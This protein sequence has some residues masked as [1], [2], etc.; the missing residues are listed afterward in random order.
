MHSISQ[1]KISRHLAQLR[2]GGLLTDKREGQWVYYQINRE[3]PRWAREMLDA[4]V[5]ATKQEE[6]Y[7]QDYERLRTMSARPKEARCVV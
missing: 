4:A 3:L 2:H 6:R 7:R 5:A 1:P